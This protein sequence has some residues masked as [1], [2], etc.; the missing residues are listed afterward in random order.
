M[1][2]II[3]SSEKRSYR[4]PQIERIILDNEISL[5]LTSPEALPL[6]SENKENNNNDP[7]KMN[8]G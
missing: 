7:F 1:K 6:W 5:A 2:T 3:E 8:V 4:S